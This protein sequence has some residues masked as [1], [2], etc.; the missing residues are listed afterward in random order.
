MIFILT[1]VHEYSKITTVLERDYAYNL[2]V[3]VSEG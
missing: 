1:L 3:D 2:V